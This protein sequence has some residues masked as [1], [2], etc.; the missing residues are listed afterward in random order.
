ME[1]TVPAVFITGKY[2]SEKIVEF[3]PKTML[4]LSH[5]WC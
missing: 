3:H 4:H 1:E 5:L 2:N